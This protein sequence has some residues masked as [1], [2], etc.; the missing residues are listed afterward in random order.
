MALTGEAKREWRK[1][2]REKQRAHGRA[3][4]A[5][6]RE[7]KA[8]DILGLTEIEQASAYLSAAQFHGKAQKIVAQWARMHPE[9]VGR[10]KTRDANCDRRHRLKVR[11]AA[12]E[13][14]GGRCECCGM[15]VPEVLEFDHRTPV[16]RRTNGIRNRDATA[17]A[18]AILNGEAGLYQLLCANCHT[19][20]TKLN[21]E[22]SG[23]AGQAWGD[24]HEAFLGDDEEKGRFH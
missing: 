3:W 24:M 16:L 2:Y 11:M 4:H 15:D 12:I 9:A 8:A 22:H 5:R 18:R 10:A 6:K 23:G 19:L 13:L 20:K 7:E 1:T 14:L 17:S 21:G